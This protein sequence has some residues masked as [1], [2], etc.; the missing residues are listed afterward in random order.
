MCLAP[1]YLP[2]S[3]GSFPLFAC[4]HRLFPLWE[5]P[6]VWAIK[7]ICTTSLNTIRTTWCLVH[8]C[9]VVARPTATPSRIEELTLHV[10][11]PERCDLRVMCC[12]SGSSS[13]TLCARNAHIKLYDVT[14][15]SW[16]N[17]VN[18][19]LLSLIASWR[20]RLVQRVCLRCILGAVVRRL[21]R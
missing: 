18:P 9:F 17:L 8:W 21:S 5:R 1:C 3:L 15:W 16:V 2:L 13:T 20:S 7:F 6:W 14:A 11:K 19:L 4:V 12:M 10:L